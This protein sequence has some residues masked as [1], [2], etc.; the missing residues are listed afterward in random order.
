M[1][2]QRE[3]IINK[4]DKN[5]LPS[6]VAIIMDGNGRW[7]KK[8][9]KI[10][11]FGHKEGAENV[12]EIVRA[13]SNLGIKEL[14]LYAFST[15]NWKRPAKEVDTIMS[16]VVKFIDSY[17]DELNKENVY[18][19]MLGRK[20]KVPDYVLDKVDYALDLTKNN[21]GMILNLCLNYGS[22]QEILDACKSL[23]KEYQNSSIEDIEK[24]NFNDFEK[25][26]YSKKYSDVDLLIRPSGELRL[27][28]FLMYQSSY[29]ELY[30]SDIL[31]PDFKKE[32]LYEAILDFQNR[33]RRFGGV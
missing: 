12:V 5:N 21:N 25:Y 17:I 16:L 4:I 10:R 29:A 30:F 11:T 32:N 15:E 22:R 1:N 26:L 2:T 13:S 33:N 27:S 20:D 31:W 24:I 28:N 3:Q 8:Q 23:V 9:N 18:L 6:H 14:S 7:A 19:Q